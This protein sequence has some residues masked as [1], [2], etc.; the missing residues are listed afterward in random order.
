MKS[1]FLVKLVSHF[2]FSSLINFPLF[3]DDEAHMDVHDRAL[4]YYRLLK[5]N[6]K[7]VQL[8]VSLFKYSILLNVYLMFI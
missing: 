5:T 6:A 4:L 2:K 1:F 3:S 8:N 7:E